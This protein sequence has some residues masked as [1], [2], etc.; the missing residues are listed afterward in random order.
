MASTVRVI[1]TDMQFAGFIQ[2]VAIHR[3]I[4]KL[5]AMLVQQQLGF[6]FI[7]FFD[8][9]GFIAGGQIYR[10]LT[11]LFGPQRIAGTTEEHAGAR[12]SDH[13]RTTAFGTFNISRRG[14]VGAHA[15][16]F[17]L[18]TA[19]LL[20]KVAIETIEQLLPVE[21]ALGNIIQLLFHGRGE[22]IIHHVSEIF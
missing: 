22:T 5:T 16:L 1:A 17:I 11:P 3:G 9:D 12:G 4:A 8:V 20:A 13:H 2:Q 19:N 6:S 18:G 10:V 7:I 14:T 21:L 15:A